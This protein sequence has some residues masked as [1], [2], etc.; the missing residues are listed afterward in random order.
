[1]RCGEMNGEQFSQSKRETCSERLPGL[2]SLR[3]TE[4]TSLETLAECPQVWFFVYNFSQTTQGW[5]GVNGFEHVHTHAF[6]RI[7]SCMLGNALQSW[8][9]LSSSLR[10]QVSHRYIHRRFAIKETIQKHNSNLCIPVAT[11]ESQQPTSLIGFLV[12]KPALPLC[13]ALPVFSL[14]MC[15][16]R[17]FMTKDLKN[18][19]LEK[20]NDLFGDLPSTLF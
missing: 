19:H 16:N 14:S 15:L 11:V 4:P 10:C 13:V 9:P 1:M 12:L 17:P 3:T 2:T 5:G 8:F 7:S 18:N 20:K 6:G